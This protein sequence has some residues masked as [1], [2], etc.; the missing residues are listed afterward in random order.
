MDNFEEKTPTMRTVMRLPPGFPIMPLQM[1]NALDTT[2]TDIPPPNLYHLS[3]LGE[4]ALYNQ[5]LNLFRVL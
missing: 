2:T 4:W 5:M 1:P 3:M